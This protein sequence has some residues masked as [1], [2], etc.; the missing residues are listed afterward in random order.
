MGTLHT[1]V[2]G[3]HISHIAR[4]YGFTSFKPIWHAAENAA[5]REKRKTPDVLF[6]G[7]Q[8][9]IP[10]RAIRE[11]PRPTDQRHRFVKQGETLM[12]RVVL[13]GFRDEP[14]KRHEGTLRV[15][16]D[17][18]NFNSKE[19]GLLEREIAPTA[20]HGLILD[21][22]EAGA[23][24]DADEQRELQLKIGHLDPVD[25]LSGQMARLNNLGYGAGPVPTR[26]LSP[27]EEADIRT[28]MT[29]RSA[30]EE[31]QCDAGLLVD[32]KCGKQ[33]QAKLLA[34]HGC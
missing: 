25:E 31:F 23:L 20:E 10:E 14:L 27:K 12:L 3:E 8:V 26:A 28:S 2:Q 29:F 24:A 4:R 11:E 34:V 32:G 16:S 22:G 7:D 15:E 13:K 21:T 33:T 9:F 18:K 1:V 19:D 17:G 6:P 5:L 30:V